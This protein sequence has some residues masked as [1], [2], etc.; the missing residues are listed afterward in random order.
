MP[1][2]AK[3][4][5]LEASYPRTETRR[6]VEILL[7]AVGIILMAIAIAVSIAMRIMPTAYS[8]ISTLF[9]VSVR[10]YEASRILA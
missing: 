9:L 1:S 3:R 10:G 8:R 5:I 2:Q 4:V 7:Y 6:S